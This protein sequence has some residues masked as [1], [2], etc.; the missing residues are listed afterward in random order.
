MTGKNTIASKCVRFE[1]KFCRN[2]N[3]VFVLVVQRSGSGVFRESSVGCS[4]L[5]LGGTTTFR[6]LSPPFLQ[7]EIYTG[8]GFY[9]FAIFLIRMSK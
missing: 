8:S 2:K 5:R 9:L 6:L 7:C 1:R 3:L 4:G